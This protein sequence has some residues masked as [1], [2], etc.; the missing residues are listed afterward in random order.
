[1]FLA[2]QRMCEQCQHGLKGQ[3]YAEYAIAQYKTGEYE[4]DHSIPVWLGG[5]NS[6]PN[7]WPPIKQNGTL[8]PSSNPPPNALR[9][10]SI[11][12]ETNATVSR[13]HWV[14][15]ARTLKPVHTVR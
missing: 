10:V 2:T 9:V 3:A 8:E 6:I 12:G 15:V 5:S 4:V 11:I 13:P 1:V 14:S 7:L